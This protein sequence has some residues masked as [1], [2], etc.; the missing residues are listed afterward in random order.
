MIGISQD[1][2]GTNIVKEFVEDQEMNYPVAMST[3]DSSSAF[4]GITAL[5]TSYFI[6]R[7]GRIVQRH[8]GML[9]KDRTELETRALAG[10]PVNAVIEEIDPVEHIELAR[11]G[12]RR[13][14]GHSGPRP[15]GG[16]GREARRAAAGES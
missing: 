11:R 14:D 3:D 8:V 15:C 9:R 7:E 10:L 12:R 4:P 1:E 16:P 6:N 13:G 2:A 5:P